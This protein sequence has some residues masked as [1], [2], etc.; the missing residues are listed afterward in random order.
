M[1]AQP[2]LALLIDGDNAQPDLFAPV[3]SAIEK[4]GHVVVK[5][6]Y[7]N[8]DSSNLQKWKKIAQAHNMQPPTPMH[9][10]GAKNETDWHLALDAMAMLDEHKLDGVCIMS[11]DQDFITLAR[12]LIE[13][14]K[15]VVMIGRE[16]SRQKYRDIGAFY[17]PIE[18]QNSQKWLMVLGLIRKHTQ[19]QTEKITEQ[20][21]AKTAPSATKPQPTAKTTPKP[22]PTAKTAPPAKP[23]AAPSQPKP[24]PPKASN[25]VSQKTLRSDERFVCQTVFATV[26]GTK[27]WVTLAEY[28][29][30]LVTAGVNYKALGHSTML[31]FVMAYPDLF[32]VREVKTLK[33]SAHHIRVK[34]RK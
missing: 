16:S 7:G 25:T 12:T 28:T 5:R 33:G 32:E 15:F 3:L 34:A 27:E 21:A 14:K 29:S 4:F 26:A 17:I 23:Q 2:R 8:L 6:V 24:T 22:Q 31:K 10:N 30:A 1:T 20:P 11:S 9:Y 18:E 19:P 13:K